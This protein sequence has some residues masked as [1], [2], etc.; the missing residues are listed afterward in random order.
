[1]NKPDAA[2]HQPGK[3]RSYWWL[4]IAC[5]FVGSVLVW[6]SQQIK[7][8]ANRVL[9]AAADQ[10]QD[11]ATRIR[12]MTV[13][14]NQYQA[15]VSGYGAASARY[16]LSLSSQVSGQVLHLGESFT[17]GSVLKKGDV[18]L[19][20]DDS[21][22]R[23]A[24]ATAAQSVAD[25]RVVLLEEQRES[26]QARTEWQSSGFKGEPDS[27]LRLREPQ[28]AAAKA[29]LVTA[30]ATLLSAR[31]DLQHTRIVAPFD[32]LVTERLISPG[33]YVSTGTHVATLMSTDRIEISLALSAREW[34]ML[35]DINQLTATDWPVEIDSV[36]GT[37]QWRG[38]VLRAEQHLD[39]RTRQRALIVGLEQPLQQSPLLP[40]GTFVKASLPGQGINDLWRLPA[41][42]LSQKSEIWYVRDEQGQKVLESFDTDALFADAEAIYIPVPEALRDQPQQVVV[43]PLSSYIKGMR[44]DPEPVTA[45]S[46][47][48]ASADKHGE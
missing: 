19:T 31:N 7:A 10:A 39:T 34:Q 26:E 38:R 22:Y 11:T 42:A 15:R 29:A 8:Q 12:V 25:A 47:L 5:G 40:V 43:Q 48:S 16:E 45:D 23:Q 27:P 9:P 21:N 46:V 6:N 2:N 3:A 44:V 13:Q 28:L 20:L 17:T 4:L 37:S 1:M 33:S 24:V 41:S 32:A 18:L 35:P 30:E 14:S 36:E